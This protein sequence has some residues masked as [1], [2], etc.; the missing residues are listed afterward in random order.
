M[1]EKI[2]QTP[3]PALV[4]AVESPAKTGP[5]KR[6]LVLGGVAAAVLLVVG[7]YTWYTHGKESTDD[8]QIEADIVPLATRVA[9]QV[10]HVAVE[11]NA[12]VK[13]GDLILELDDADYA[14]R[15]QQ[16]EAELETAQAQAAA[17]DAQ[18]QVASAGARG[19]FTSARAGVSGSSAQLATAQAGLLRAQA[20]EK[21]ASL[22]LQRSKELRAASVVPQSKL[23][24]DQA[25]YDV[26]HAAVAQ[27]QAALEAAQS[28][29]GE[30][31]GRLDQSAPVAAAV[32]ASVAQ[33]RLA[34]A[35]EKSAEAT[36]ALAR[37][38]LGYTK[39][40]AEKDG[41]VTR[42]TAREGQ[43]VQP[44]QPLASLVPD[45]TYL[46]A[47]FKE[48]QIG[49]MKPGDVV[50]ISVDAYSGHELHGKVES[51]AGGTGARFSL[52]PPDNASGNFVKVV[53]RVPVRIAWVDPP[54][55]L[56]LRP[57]LSADVTVHVK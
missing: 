29:I 28:R 54:K 11:D 55:D 8:A 33:A 7:G 47:N 16:A 2:Q 12:H 50:D 10:K 32:A 52:L 31:R 41:Q 37:L 18:V 56:V 20:E 5:R 14:A 45:Q 21:K 26:A 30:A 9:G 34:H 15:A 42:L 4:R 57:G 22:E 44:G 1:A 3:E 43:M 51:L 6:W 25:A 19:G 48:T 38:Q 24:D 49:E 17:A 36:L 53:Q 46:V 40:Y 35:K 27:A 23:D 13:K 39:L